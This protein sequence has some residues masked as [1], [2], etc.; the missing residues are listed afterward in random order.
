MI[1]TAGDDGVATPVVWMPAHTAAGAIGSACDSKGRRVTALMWRANR[2][3]DG[4][5]KQAAARWKDWAQGSVQ[6][7]GGPAH[8]FS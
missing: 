2:L 5:A 3:A 6:K 8:R 1:H 7:G 4:L